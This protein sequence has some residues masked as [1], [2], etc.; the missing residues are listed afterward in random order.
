MRL[1]QALYAVPSRRARLTVFDE[2]NVLSAMG[3]SDRSQVALMG[4]R[5]GCF[6]SVAAIVAQQER[7]ERLSRLRPGPCGIDAGAT[8]VPDHFVALVRDQHE[9][10]FCRT[11]QS[12]K[13]QRIAPIGLHPTARLA[14]DFGVRHHLTAVT[15][16]TQLAREHK[17]A[18]SNLI[19][20]QQPTWVAKLGR[21]LAQPG[22]LRAHRPHDAPRLTP[23]LAWRA[24]ICG[25]A[26]ILSAGTS[27]PADRKFFA[28][29]FPIARDSA[30][31]CV[32][33]PHRIQ[34]S[35]ARGPFVPC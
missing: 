23:A 2:S 3:N 11:R 14:W 30:P 8:Q 33:D 13:T 27:S 19:H 17:V 32:T 18:R 26:A 5:P 7:L 6:A 9:R 31:R 28:T 24:M 1:A 4:R 20:D 34:R 10:Q 22:E 21:S 35:A 12:G 16:G 25:A 15:R 29:G